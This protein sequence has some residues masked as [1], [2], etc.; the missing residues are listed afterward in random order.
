M[1]ASTNGTKLEIINI[2]GSVQVGK[3]RL[4]IHLMEFI[5]W[6]LGNFATNT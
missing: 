4:A 1:A 2:E 3:L 6:V 5:Q